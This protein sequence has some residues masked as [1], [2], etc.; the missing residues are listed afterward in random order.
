[1]NRKKIALFLAGAVLIAGL[2]YWLISPHKAAVS[3]ERNPASPLVAQAETPKHFGGFL[4]PVPEPKLFK[5]KTYPPETPEEK[6]MWE[7]Y[8]YMEKTDR[9]W[10]WKRPVNF[11][12]K[13][14]DEKE[15][16]VPGAEVKWNLASV[17]RTREGTVLTDSAGLF[18]VENERG[19][20]IQFFI[21]KAGYY[22]GKQSQGDAEYASFSEDIF[23]VPDAEHPVLFHLRKKGPAEHLLHYNVSIDLPVNQPPIYYDFA[24]G[25]FGPSGQ[26]IF[27]I[28]RA[29][30]TGPTSFDWSVTIQ[31]APGG[32]LIPTKDEF[33]FLPP[34]SGYQSS[35][36]IGHKQ[37]DPTPSRA[38]T[39]QFY[40][41]TSDGK[42]A[43]IK[44]EIAQFNV[45]EAGVSVMSYL[46]P[47]PGHLN[48]EYDPS[49]PDGDN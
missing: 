11:Y 25:K 12:G 35:W 20:R 42:Y 37:N 14:L 4:P 46:N 9:D 3:S 41:R 31:A 48:L 30:Q 28:T 34:E 45:P 17:D 47:Q 19:K 24:T 7:W 5:S 16:P 22:A 15:Q 21:E 26:L 44:L 29:N 39:P 6:A 18:K 40:I 2:V 36:S 23:Y 43:A 33:M 38:L 13:V 1:M 32:G 10:P 8:D 27:T 49:H